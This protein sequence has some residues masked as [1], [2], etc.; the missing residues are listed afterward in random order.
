MEAEQYI[1]QEIQIS[2]TLQTAHS[3]TIM[4][5]ILYVNEYQYLLSLSDYFIEYT[6]CQVKIK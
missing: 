2:R 4:P 3:L 1:F 5:V 6:G